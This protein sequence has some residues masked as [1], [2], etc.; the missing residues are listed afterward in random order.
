MQPE[1]ILSDSLEI[2]SH[3]SH[4]RR[5]SC[6]SCRLSAANGQ[7]VN[8]SQGG[9]STENYSGMVDLTG[10]LTDD[11]YAEYRDYFTSTERIG[12][13]IHDE[14]SL[15]ERS[16]LGYSWSQ[17][18]GRDTVIDKAFADI[19]PYIDLDFYKTETASDARIHIYRV[20]PIS[21][22]SVLERGLGIAL[23]SNE[24]SFLPSSGTPGPFQ[25]AAWKDFGGDGNPFLVDENGYDYGI[26]RWEDA[27]TIIHEI[28]HTL[29]LSHPQT[30]GIDDPEAIRYDTSDTIM[31]YNSDITYDRNGIYAYAPSWSSADVATLQSIWG[32]ENG[33]N[34]HPT[35]NSDT[36]TIASSTQ[37]LFLFQ[38]N[39]RANGGAGKDTVYGNQ[40]L[41]TITGGFGEDILYGGKD[42][43]HIYGNQ[44]EDRLY[45]NLGDDLIYGGKS[46]DWQHGGQGDDR[47]YGNLGEDVIYGGRSNDWLHGGQGDDVLYGNHD[48]DVFNLSRGSDRVMDFEAN[49]GD[50]IA[51]QSGVNYV[52]QAQGSDLLINTDIG[53]LLLVGTEFSSFNPTQSIVQI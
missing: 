8:S 19:D 13:Y 20:S 9:I 25:T 1:N 24:Y 49:E 14:F 27:A 12:Y 22:P 31:S 21:P 42:A 3:L 17:G 52:I 16:T 29:G 36:I 48:A 6:D 46:N 45:G 43:D 47:L 50:R 38:G 23:G 5:C 11:F 34:D 2:V 44:D 40:G 32:S 37:S 39:D 33:N 51:I 53:S 30:N 18:L 28:G 4:N 15:I 26:V 35:N 7:Q 10:S 41:D